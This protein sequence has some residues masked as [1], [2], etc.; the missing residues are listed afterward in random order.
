MLITCMLMRPAKSSLSPPS[1]PQNSLSVLLHKSARLLRRRFE[2]KSHHL[3]LTRS[4]W[5]VLAYLSRQPGARQSSLAEQ[6][7]I[8]PI[9]LGR[10]IDKLETAAL[11][12]RRNDPGDRRAWSLHLTERAYPLLIELAPIIETVRD[13]ALA[14]LSEADRATFIRA[15]ETI[16]RNLG[17]APCSDVR[18][19]KARRKP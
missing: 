14:G 6:I 3:G 8:E 5:Q 9:T 4:Q 18:E 19:L 11:V 17:N 7:D 13:E 12:E 15:L 10:I 1:L 16:R 2:Q